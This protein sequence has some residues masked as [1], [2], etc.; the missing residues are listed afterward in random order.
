MKVYHKVIAKIVR[1]TWVG[2]TRMRAFLFVPIN[3]FI[4]IQCSRVLEVITTHPL[5]YFVKHIGNIQ[6]TLTHFNASNT[7]KNVQMKEQKEMSNDNINNIM[8]TL[9]LQW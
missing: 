8:I 6:K 3:S 5:M 9:T 4:F 1:I 2:T 7:T